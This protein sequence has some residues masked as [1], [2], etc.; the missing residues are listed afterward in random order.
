MNWTGLAATLTTHPAVPPFTSN[1]SYRRTF[2]L[3]HVH[4]VLPGKAKLS[5]S[6]FWRLKT[7]VLGSLITCVAFVNGVN[8]LQGN[9]YNLRDKFIL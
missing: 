1:W 8:K 7:L 4:F 3:A 9:K 2:Y 6:K 5:F